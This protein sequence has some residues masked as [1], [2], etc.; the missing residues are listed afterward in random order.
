M[1]SFQ[2][3]GSLGEDE[4][5]E[6]LSWMQQAG[7]KYGMPVMTEV[8]GELQAGLIAEYSDILQ[9]GSRN[10]QNFT[11]KKEATTQWTAPMSFHPP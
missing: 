4:A 9:I 8:R 6:A 1:H 7:R 5:R 11:E 2:G 3:L 10:M